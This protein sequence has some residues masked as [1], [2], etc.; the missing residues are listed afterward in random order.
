MKT[1][2]EESLEAR[3]R[4]RIECYIADAMSAKE[5]EDF[6]ADM[7]ADTEFTK[8]VTAVYLAKIRQ[9]KQ[10]KLVNNQLVVI[11]TAC[12]K[13]H[14]SRNWFNKIFCFSSI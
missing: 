12:S 1:L 13:N 11:D 10:S 4:Q 3:I 14:I 7:D 6:E 8:E 5:R 9:K 2:Q